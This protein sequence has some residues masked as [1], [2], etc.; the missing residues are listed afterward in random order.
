MKGV[1]R[2]IGQ[3]VE[4]E[5]G[6][7]KR[8]SARLERVGWR[9]ARSNSTFDDHANDQRIRSD[10]TNQTFNRKQSNRESRRLVFRGHLQQ[11]V[12]CRVGLVMI[13]VVVV[14]FVVLAFMSSHI[15]SG[16]A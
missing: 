4:T 5:E 14:T 13:A 8:G 7:G 6:L 3:R 16:N 12:R 9:F 10:Q 2:R 1:T 15:R 11:M